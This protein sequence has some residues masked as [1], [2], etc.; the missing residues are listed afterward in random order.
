MSRNK[1]IDFFTGT[2]VYNNDKDYSDFAYFSAPLN[3]FFLACLV[4][5]S[6][7]FVSEYTYD[8]CIG[9]CMCF[10]LHVIRHNFETFQRFMVSLCSSCRS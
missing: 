9:S 8:D 10:A 1:V 3:I 4:L 2:P 7:F 6:D 5:H